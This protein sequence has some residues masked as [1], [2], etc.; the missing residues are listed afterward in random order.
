[1]PS[2]EW[3]FAFSS[4]VI[5][6]ASKIKVPYKSRNYQFRLTRH[7]TLRPVRA[8]RVQPAQVDHD[9]H[10][11]VEVRVDEAALETTIRRLGWRIYGT[12]QPLASLSHAQAVLA[13]RSAYQA[14]HSFVRLKRHSLS[15]TPMHVQRDDHATRLIRLL[16]I[17]LRC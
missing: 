13:S 9:C 7:D 5:P 17:A 4:R 8:Y 14:E 2:D 12:N 6:K 1:M 11:P 16:S 3:G 10:A 15:L